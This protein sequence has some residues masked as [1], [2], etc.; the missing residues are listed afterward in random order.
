M[1]YSAQADILEQLP[2]A[3]LIE[4]TDDAGAGAVDADAVTRA[5]ADADATIDA[6]AQ[7]RYSVPLSATPDKI[8]QVSVDLAIYNL[9]S[10]LDSVPEVRADRKKD[11]VRFLE[12][13]SD[14]K[15]DLGLET[16]AEANSG[17]SVD[18]DNETRIFT[19]TKM[20]GF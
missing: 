12:R 13:L 5:I 10:R 18:I 1:A 3:T 8:R 17:A 15:I 20:S 16:V 14:G 11:A 4:L 9:F 7:A 6:Y 19:R 2:A